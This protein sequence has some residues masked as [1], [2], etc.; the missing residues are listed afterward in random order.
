MR[1]SRAGI[2][3]L[4]AIGLISVCLGGLSGCESKPADGTV[5]A[6]EAKPLTDEQKAAHRKFYPD[7][8]KK[9]ARAGGR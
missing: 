5:I 1:I 3:S 9:S 4:A 6:N 2:S 7:R 8:S